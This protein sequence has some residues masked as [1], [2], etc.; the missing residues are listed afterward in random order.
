MARVLTVDDSATMR[1]MPWAALQGAG[2]DVLIIEV[3]LP[4]MGGSKLSEGGPVPAP[5]SGE[6]WT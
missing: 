6:A 3:D 4:S 1:A 5:G 2:H